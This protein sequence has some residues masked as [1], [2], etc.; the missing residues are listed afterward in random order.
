M[1]FKWEL[2]TLGASER[3]KRGRCFSGMVISRQLKNYGEGTRR[4]MIGARLVRS[5]VTRIPLSYRGHVWL[6]FIVSYPVANS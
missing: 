1:G 5:I 6:R 3:E 2:W 4:A